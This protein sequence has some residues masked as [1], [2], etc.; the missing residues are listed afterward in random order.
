MI[1]TRFCMG[2]KRLFPQHATTRVWGSYGLE[3]GP[4][5]EI[6]AHRPLWPTTRLDA[7]PFPS[8]EILPL[9][10]CLFVGDPLQLLKVSA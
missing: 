3:L 4:F 6:R 1:R 5:L 9:T 7:T 2:V 10:E 8:V